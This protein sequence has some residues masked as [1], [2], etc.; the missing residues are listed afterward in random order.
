MTGRFMRAIRVIVGILNPRKWRT[1]FKT[2]EETAFDYAFNVSWS[3]AGEDIGLISALHAIKNGR[4]L[5]VGAHHPSRFS[6]TR[7]LN[8][9]GWSGVNID[10]NPSLLKAFERLSCPKSM[11]IV[12]GA[13]HLFPEPGA[14]AV[15]T[16]LATEWF[17]RYLSY[18]ISSTS[19]NTQAGV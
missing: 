4:Y 9:L 14:M 11:T 8:N 13:S 7:K 5:D 10:A 12:A 2:F 3:Q 18:M 17:E 15:V 19:P 6:V 16:A 1:I